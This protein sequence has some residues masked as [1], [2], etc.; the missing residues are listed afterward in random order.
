MTDVTLKGISGVVCHDVTERHSGVAC[1]DVWI[2]DTSRKETLCLHGD[3]RQVISL[4]KM[5]L[6]FIA[7]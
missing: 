3:A 5:C 2:S 1:H 7:W 6:G 4:F